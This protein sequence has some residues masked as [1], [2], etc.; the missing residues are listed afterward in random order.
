MSD[1]VERNA[2]ICL[3]LDFL[4]CSFYLLILHL[5]YQKI[6]VFLMIVLAGKLDQVTV[7]EKP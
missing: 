6:N 4:M 2:L 7:E 3:D 1:S 5:L